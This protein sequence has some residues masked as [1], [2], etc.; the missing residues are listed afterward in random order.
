MPIGIDPWLLTGRPNALDPIVNNK[1]R[2][3]VGAFNQEMYCQSV[4]FPTWETE[5]RQIREVNRQYPINSL[6]NRTTLTPL[7]LSGV[8]LRARNAALEWIEEACKRKQGLIKN[9]GYRQNVRIDVMDRASNIVNSYLFTNCIPI[10]YTAIQRLDGV[11]PELC[12]DSLELLPEGMEC[13]E[14]NDISILGALGV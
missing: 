2:V 5:T 12:I 1:Y 9:A 8:L 13:T 4:G 7:I 6:T 10:R 14:V 3:Y 11:R